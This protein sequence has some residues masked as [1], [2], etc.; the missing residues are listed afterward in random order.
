[1]KR[2]SKMKE[3]LKKLISNY[4]FWTGLSASV[5]L[6]LNSIAKIFGFSINNKIVDDIIMSICGVLVVFGVVSIPPSS[7]N[8]ATTEIT[9]KTEDSSKQ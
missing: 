9:E 8:K 4:G 2:I 6:L 3:K 5:V 1:M 7:K